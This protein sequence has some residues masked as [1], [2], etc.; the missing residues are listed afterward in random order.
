MVMSDG[1]IP[2][3][4]EDPTIDTVYSL[5]QISRADLDP[6]CKASM[7][8]HFE[9][10]IKDIVQPCGYT[11]SVIDYFIHGY[12]ERQ[13]IGLLIRLLKSHPVYGLHE[14]SD[15]IIRLYSESLNNRR[16]G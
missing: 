1:G 5:Y 7:E 6:E 2:N 16:I 12:R 4:D 13:D 8:D 9:F 3:F 15:K 11:E 10:G 14:I